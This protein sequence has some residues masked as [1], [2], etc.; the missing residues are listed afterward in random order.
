ADGRRL[1]RPGAEALPRGAVSDPREGDERARGGEQR[2]A[3][4]VIPDASGRL[5]QA[6][7]EVGGEQIERVVGDAR[8]DVDATVVV[9]GL[10]VVLEVRRL[11]V[12]AEQRIG[13]G[14]AGT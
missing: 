5:P 6:A 4:R 12:L 1:V 10:D 7:A 8:V 3:Q 13:V 11:R 14:E 2:V 9:D